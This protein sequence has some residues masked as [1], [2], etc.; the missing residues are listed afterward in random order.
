MKLRTADR[1]SLS[2]AIT[3]D[4]RA[5][6]S[7]FR[8]RP[9][10]SDTYTPRW[11]APDR[12]ADKAASGRRSAVYSVLPSNSPNPGQ[13]CGVHWGR[14]ADATF[15]GKTGSRTAT[16]SRRVQLRHRVRNL[17]ETSY[18]D[19]MNAN[20]PWSRLIRYDA[21]ICLHRSSNET[22]KD[23]LRDRRGGV[24]TFVACGSPGGEADV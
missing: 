20:R 4:C 9:V 23:S 17:F 1:H 2:R 8:P 3:S 19:S 16:P 7:P 21:G 5:E 24:T 18:I 14:V 6:G 22:E 11:I 13:P 15:F 10:S 12:T